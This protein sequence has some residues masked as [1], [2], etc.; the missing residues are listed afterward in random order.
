M[1]ADAAVIVTTIDT[2]INT[3]F[4]VRGKDEHI[5]CPKCK[6]P[7]GPFAKCRCQLKNPKK[8][9]CDCEPDS[10]EKFSFFYIYTLEID[11]QTNED[12][13]KARHQSIDVIADINIEANPFSHCVVDLWDKYY[14]LSKA[15][16]IEV[17]GPGWHQFHI[18]KYGTPTK[19]CYCE[20]LAE[21]EDFK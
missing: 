5:N 21:S 16:A 18:S 9:S 4:F 17:I 10:K 12:Y 1:G 8:F 6:G 14:N 3:M 13:N 19:W 20:E 11:W 2:R 7:N 15:E